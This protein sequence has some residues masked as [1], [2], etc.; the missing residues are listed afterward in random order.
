[1]KEMQG[2][3]ICYFSLL[4][5]G[6]VTGDFKY[7]STSESFKIT[8]YDRFTNGNVTVAALSLLC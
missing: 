3:D 1:M 6:A 8:K 2:R 7:N 5:R 4:W